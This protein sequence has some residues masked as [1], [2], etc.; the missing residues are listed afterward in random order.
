MNIEDDGLIEIK[1]PKWQK[2]GG[3]SLLVRPESTDGIIPA[4]YGAEIG[5]AHV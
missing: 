2:K 1:L 5:R 4:N 3:T